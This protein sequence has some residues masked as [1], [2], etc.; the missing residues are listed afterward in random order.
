[1]AANLP[2]E[3][4][5]RVLDQYP[6]TN[7]YGRRTI[8]RCGLVCRS[9]AVA[10][11]YQLFRDVNLNEHNILSFLS[12]VSTSF[13][14]VPSVIRSLGLASGRTDRALSENIPK[15]G[16]LPLVTTLRVTMDEA[17][18][19]PNLPLLKDL[20]PNITSLAF[21]NC[22]LPL[23]P[24]LD[25][26]REFRRLESLSLSWVHIPRFTLPSSYEAH[27]N[28]RHLS[29]D[30]LPFSPVPPKKKTTT[31]DF[32]G[33][34]LQL[35]PVPTLH[36][37]SVRGHDPSSEA[38]LAQYLR[39]HGRQLQSLSIETEEH[40]FQRIP[41]LSF[42]TELRQ[43]DIVFNFHGF[44]LI[45]EQILRTLNDV[46]SRALKRVNV[47]DVYGAGL[48]GGGQ[49]TAI[50]NLFASDKIFS[51]LESF[52]F[53]TSN[54]QSCEKVK[55]SMPLSAGRGILRVERM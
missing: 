40:A 31:E 35:D 25:A 13:F 28:W 15:L 7:Y 52:R 53:K 17:V 38:K 41:S 8:A 50:D 5:D 33:A 21:I 26:T 46:N 18:F 22:E 23:V 20:F 9:W 45:D 27:P 19:E 32:F 43:L 11:R 39:L 6:V 1:M 54:V 30:L 49:W 37:L 44:T 12:V 55:Q 14:P 3:L 34:V 36:S 10:S 47:I 2:L 16:E 4:L 24:I 42:C 48:R 51:K 29:I